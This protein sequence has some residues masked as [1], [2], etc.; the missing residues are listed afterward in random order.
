VVFV[1]NRRRVSIDDRVNDLQAVSLI[2]RL[3]ERQ[4]SGFY[5]G[6]V[7]LEKVECRLLYL[8]VRV[9]R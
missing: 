9:L 5:A 8:V 1:S 6:I 2:N 3:H 7:N 4:R